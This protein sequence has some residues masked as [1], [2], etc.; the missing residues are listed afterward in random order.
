MV[1]A[2]PADGPLTPAVVGHL[3]RDLVTRGRSQALIE[4]PDDEPLRLTPIRAWPNNGRWTGHTIEPDGYDQR[5]VRNAPSAAVFN[6]EFAS[7][8][9]RIRDGLSSAD[10][11]TETEAHLAAEASSRPVKALTQDLNLVG[12]SSNQWGEI[13]AGLRDNP[14]VSV[15]APGVGTHVHHMRANPADSMVELRAQLLRDIEA[16][17]GIGGILT[18]TDA[19]AI[20]ALWRVATVR[21]FNPVARLIEAEAERKLNASYSF[22][23]DAWIAAPQVELSRGLAQRATGVQRL[24]TAG[25]EVAE[26]RRV[27]GLA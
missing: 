4:V 25:M 7:R 8:R 27:M 11:L 5:E 14:G 3:V 10:I 22:N 18:V 21:T 20:Q 19:A 26:A 2:A 24:V 15:I 1:A 6:I 16:L 17:C 9:G 13:A 23:R 12:S